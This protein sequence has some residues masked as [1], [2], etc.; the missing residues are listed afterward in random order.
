MSQPGTAEL[1]CDQ[2][3]STWRIE[4]GAVTRTSWRRALGG[5]SAAPQRSRKRCRRENRFGT[6]ADAHWRGVSANWRRSGC[7]SL[8]LCSSEGYGFVGYVGCRKNVDSTR[9]SA[10]SNALVMPSAGNPTATGA[11]ILSK[12]SE[13]TVHAGPHSRAI[14][15]NSFFVPGPERSVAAFQEQRVLRRCGHSMVEDFR[16]R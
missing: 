8:K 16:A 10:S 13:G 1:A 6:G 15:M 12:Q 14:P 2:P 7:V 4:P 11:F 3:P 5:G 9:R